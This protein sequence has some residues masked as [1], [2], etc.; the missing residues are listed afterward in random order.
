MDEV[1][2]KVPF[3]SI[4]LLHEIQQ[5]TYP[6]LSESVAHFHCIFS[7]T[8]DLE[9]NVENHLCMFTIKNNSVPSFFFHST[10]LLT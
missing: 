6:P 9:E 4:M 8:A 3:D 1:I 10:E 7:L 2:I 5:N